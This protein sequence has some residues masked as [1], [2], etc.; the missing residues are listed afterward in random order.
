MRF[1]IGLALLGMVGCT[2]NEADE[3]WHCEET[4]TAI[5]MS[6]VTSL[7]FAAE[8]V[9]AHVGATESATFTYEDATTTPL[10]LS[11]TGAG[12]ATFVDGEAVYE[13]DGHN[14]PLIDLE[15]PPRI[16]VDGT[17]A[18]ATEDGLFDEVLEVVVV[19]TVAEEAVIDEPLPLGAM[20][21][22]FTL[23][24]F[25]D[26]ADPWDAESAAL[27]ATYADG[28]SVG[29]VDGQISGEEACDDGDVCTAWAATVAVGTWGAFAE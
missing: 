14:I 4:R 19:G 13:G 17:L 10:S 27:R 29:S 22:T 16:E 8:A 5:E 9:V 28:V 26:S 11:F 1:T 20:G 15:C 6:E 24:P 7:G 3:G 23:T 25:I 12:T 18:F 2:R 21:G